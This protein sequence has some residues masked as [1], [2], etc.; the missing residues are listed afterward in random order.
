MLG[1]IFVPRR[2]GGAGEVTI[3]D[4]AIAFGYEVDK[5]SEKKVNDSIQSLKSTATKLLG[6]IGVGFSLAKLKD[7]S[8]EFGSVNDK[9]RDATRGMGEQADIQKAILDAANGA[10]QSYGDMADTVGKLAQN[11]DVFSG[12]G[13]AAEFAGLLYKNFMATGKSAQESNALVNRLTT[14]I[15]KGAVDSSSMMSLF[16]ESPGTVRMLADSMGV[17]AD[18]LQDMV[19][20]GKVSAA[21]LR[22]AFVANAGSIESRFGELG[23]GISGAMRNI[24]NQWGLFVAETDDM[25]KIT[26]SIAKMMVSG[27]SRVVVVLRRA[28][29]AVAKVADRLGGVQNLMKLV[30]I[31]VGA[32]VAA[33]NA[34]KILSFIKGVGS[35]L[36]KINAKMLLI[37]AVI[38]LIALAIDDLIHFMRGDNSLMGEMFEKF[39]I[40]GDAVR[41]TIDGIIDSAKAL[42]P[43]VADMAKKFGGVLLGALK[44]LLPHLIDFGK[45]IL[46][47]IVDFVK[48]LAP[49]LMDVGK[50]V[51]G[52]IFRSLEKILPML[53]STISRILPTVISLVEKLL[54]F[55]MEVSE[56]VLPAILKVVET[57]LPLL[58]QIIKAVLPVALD[59]ID[60]LLPLVLQFVEAVLPVII[61]LIETLLPLVMQIIEAVLPVIISLIEAALPLLM[62]IVEA[63]LPIILD[64]ILELLPLVTEI[65]EAILPIILELITAILPILEPII[66][67]V[68]SLVSALLPPV[69]SLLNAILPI[70]E[71]IL[72]VLK[73]IADVIGV[74]VDLISTIIGWIG[75]GFSWVVG[76]FTG[77]GS[78]VSIQTD[79]GGNPVQQNAR[80]T[81]WS[82]DTFV[83]GEEGPELVTGARGRKVFTA[84]QTGD[85]F[86]TL[87][88][89]AS[90]SVRPRPETVSAAV[91]SVENRAVTQY[92][93]ISNVFN[94][95]RAGQK[96]SAEAMGRA[97]GDITG[98]L[99][100]AM[101]FVK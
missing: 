60:A 27:F 44:E 7:L 10:R 43:L 92:I 24:R 54:P 70:L 82:A 35:G 34:G 16:R 80:G 41:E 25:L 59:L 37:V 22:D 65:I 66:E 62:Q 52:A 2:E 18:A 71:P 9:I 85:V 90:M 75:K 21:A 30:G 93:E 51:L 26:Q 12:V 23:Y 42:L 47:P 32:V 33:M 31:T 99:A 77:G 5:S 58:F 11:A 1:G 94:G 20:K 91:Q 78:N 79:S 36:G 53:I 84:A 39:G 56:K 76:L 3:R 86:R 95:D 48:R 61:N 6:A 17:T 72:K 38:V 89:I 45:K 57:L 50:R 19:S 74:I 98:E 97:S 40:D 64:I 68:G 100:R 63:I 29:D 101:A 87:A 55:I 81:S 88:D 83:A 46:P 69:V 14:S 13:E 28:R 49:L 15:T 4:I 73:P 67:L 8:E 96:R